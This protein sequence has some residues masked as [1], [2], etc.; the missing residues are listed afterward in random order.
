Y[1][2][3]RD[4]Q[5]TQDRQS[6]RRENFTADA[7]SEDHGEYREDG[8]AFGQE[9][10]AEPMDRPLDHRL[11]K[12]FQRLDFFQAAALVDGF[13]EIDQHDDAGLG[14]H[15]EAGNEADPNRDAEIHR[16]RVPAAFD[17]GEQ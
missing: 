7:G 8:H 5:A 16:R 1:D 11:P 10:G 2:F 3:V 6:H 12:L 15:A 14:G 13:A 9:L 4:Q 17:L